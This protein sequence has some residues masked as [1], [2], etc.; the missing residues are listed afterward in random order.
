MRK[1]RLVRAARLLRKAGMSDAR[2]ARLVGYPTLRK[3]DVSVNGSSIRS[4]VTLN[5]KNTRRVVDLE[6]GGR[7]EFTGEFIPSPV[8]TKQSSV[9]I[10]VSRGD[11]DWSVDPIAVEA[12]YDNGDTVSK[13]YGKEL[14]GDSTSENTVT[15]ISVPVPPPSGWE[16]LD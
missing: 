1:R 8:V 12:T 14:S 10:E 9:E 11:S 13:S 2:A 3:L 6:E 5:D 16:A 15:E 7:A 4:K